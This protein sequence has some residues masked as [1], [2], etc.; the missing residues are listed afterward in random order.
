LR[1]ES[2]W[3]KKKTEDFVKSMGRRRWLKKNA[4]FRL[5]VKGEGEKRGRKT[6]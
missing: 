5:G 3:G 6:G 1:T 2:P 4:L